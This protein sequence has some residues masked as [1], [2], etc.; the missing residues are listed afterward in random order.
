MAFHPALNLRCLAKRVAL[1]I[2][3]IQRLQQ[4]RLAL[5]QEVTHYARVNA[6]ITAERDS[7]LEAARQA[8]IESNRQAKDIQTLNTA[9]ALTS[10]Q[11][12]ELQDNEKAARERAAWCERLMDALRDQ[13]DLVANSTTASLNR[14]VAVCPTD[15]AVLYLLSPGNRRT[16]VYPLADGTLAL[17]PL[18]NQTTQG[19]CLITLPK[20]G[21]YLAAALLRALGLV[22]CGVH[23]DRFGFSD[24]RDKSLDDI[25][26]D[27]QKFVTRIPIEVAAGLTGVGQFIVGHL[28]HSP[29]TVEATAHLRRILLIR[30][31][32][33]ALVS[34]MR[35]FELPG[36]AKSAPKPWMAQADGPGRLLAFLDQW[37]ATL[38]DIMRTA[39]GWL[40]EPKVL[41][42]KFEEL[43]GDAG[44]EVQ[45]RTL[46]ALASHVGVSVPTDI[47]SLFK[48]D[49]I[50]KPTLTWSGRRS[51]AWR[52]W[53]ERVATRFI[54]LGGGALQTD[55]GYT[56][57]DGR[58]LVHAAE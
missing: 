29:Q 19:V 27:Y 36:Y 48:Q 55:F 8:Q 4:H 42:L 40:R 52:Y 47:V 33:D 45:R 46:E 57:M 16:A 3:P 31:P 32:L 41:L 5:L 24:Y 12:A 54:Q 43:M 11:V 28:E 18:T 21:T 49:V 17:S 53:D 35:F 13:H 58:T 20:A 23:A 2:G 38:I 37:G 7:A 15:Y 50:G 26:A 1:T 22:D 6:G 25:R 34:C 39:V 51:E 9:L 56:G 10:V 14:S 30:N 44:L